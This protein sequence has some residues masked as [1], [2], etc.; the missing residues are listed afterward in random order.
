M[1][2]YLLKLY[3]LL[4]MSLLLSQGIVI[5]GQAQSIHNRFKNPSTKTGPDIENATSDWNIE[6]DKNE[7]SNE[8]F[9]F[10]SESLAQQSNKSEG[11]LPVFEPK[12]E[13]PEDKAQENF[14]LVGQ[15]PTQG[16]FAREQLKQNSIRNHF[17]NQGV[18]NFVVKGRVID[19]EDGTPIPGV[20]VIIKGTT[21]GTTTNMD[22]I[23]SITVPEEN[24]ILLF[25][26]IGYKQQEVKINGRSTI[27]ISLVTDVTQMNEV[28]IVGFGTQK[29]EMVTGS[30]SSIETK[31]LLQSPVANIS[32]ALA[33][34]L[35]GLIAVQGTGEPGQD[36]SNL[37][38]RGIGT[39]SGNQDPLIMVD[40]IEV[41]NFNNIDPNEIE[42][43]TVLK[44]AASTAVYGVRG[45]NGVILITTKRGK[46]GAPQVNIT[47]NFAVKRF[48]D[49]RRS[50]NA[51]DYAR[52]FN[53]ALINDSFVT[54]ST[55]APRFSDEQIAHY[56]D[57]TDPIRHPDTN[58]F[59]LLF[60]PTSSQQQHNVNINGG[61]E[62]VKY[63]VS[64]GHFNQEGL[65]RDIKDEVN[66][67]WDPTIKFK[68]YNLR[69]NFD[70]SITNRLSAQI[71][72]DAQIENRQ[73]PRNDTERLV[74]MAARVSPVTSPG[75][76][77]GRLINRPDL[78]ITAVNPFEQAYGQGGLRDNR[79]FLNG[80]IRLDY[81]LDF[82]TE[83]LTSHAS[84]SYN[85]FNQH[86]QHVITNL[87]MYR[88]DLHPVTGEILY[89]PLNQKAPFRYEENFGKNRRE[90]MEAGLN[91]ARKFGDHIVTG[92]VLYN[93]IKFYDPQ[94]EF[95]VPNGYQS[96][97]GRFTYD[98]KGRYQI[99]YNIGYNGTENFSPENRFGYFPAYSVGWVPT[100]EK[101]FPKNNIITYMKLRASYGEV[102]NDRVRDFTAP[103]SRFLFRPSSYNIFPAG[104]NNI[105]NYFFGEVGSSYQRYSGSREGILGNPLL[106]WER[107]RKTNIGVDF[108]IFKSKI[109]LTVDYF[110][111]NRD[112]ILTQLNTAPTII[113]A[114]LPA[115]NIGSMNNRGFDGDISY[116]GKVG[117]VN[118]WVR[119]N[120]T[121]ARN[122]ILF[123]DEVTRDYP[124]QQRTGHRHGQFF[125][126]LAD[127]FYNSW[128]EV[129]DPNRPISIHQNNRL[130]PGDIRYVDINGDGVIDFNDEVPIG[131]SNFPEKMYGISFG[132]DYKGFDISVLFQGAGNV[133]YVYERNLAR[134]FT[135][136]NG[137]VEYLLNSWS[138]ER[139]EQGLP[140]DF[141]RLTVDNGNHNYV[142]STQWVR[143]ASYLRLK[144]VE[145]GYTFQ[146]NTLNRLGLASARIFTNGMNLF[147]WSNMFQ[148]VDPES[149]PTQV[150]REPYPIVQ[151]FN[152]GLN[153][154]F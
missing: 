127:G 33:G 76:V 57:G 132:G 124:Y 16:I 145:I 100:Q 102:G 47:S 150:N 95:L 137:A 123:Q 11:K 22:G 45:G 61:T 139:F 153:I 48:T 68:R 44:D 144:N 96:F 9:Q 74:E 101:F 27:D 66:L 141:P 151:T 55:L 80:T 122:I 28:V 136:G 103:G 97:V 37:R 143:D 25:S 75:I 4:T 148:G 112:D 20:N 70:F 78:G 19:Q 146:G 2:H 85:N 91:Y 114:D 152:M 21:I 108:S 71:N 60:A 23:Y 134:G 39:F 54:G 6:K 106:T 13:G 138:P 79:D 118:F 98:F 154:K 104:S 43:L 42:S 147:T 120:Y 133:S 41:L 17:P 32:N 15:K 130:Q 34:R 88:P 59:D 131:Y 86:V 81:E 119:G 90:Y 53:Q 128:D 40:G 84:L 51:Y 149:A 10:S 109:N 99:E 73:R 26:F 72:L 105:N 125:G 94:L 77:D 63:F 8:I 35:P 3:S 113:G 111:E 1:I 52:S 56:R 87:P 135:Q 5:Y 129:N 7:E 110:N 18:N 116:S 89:V 31:E 67:G 115:Y 49:L 83:G 140:I 121:F 30:I 36:Y 69:S 92:L 58:W 24:S 126:L 29:K 62:K 38:I 14:K 50:M 82:I 107:A 64:V 93:Q 12:P 65:L 46:I 117:L 142:R